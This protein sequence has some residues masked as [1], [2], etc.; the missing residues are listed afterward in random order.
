MFCCG[1]LKLP[2]PHSLK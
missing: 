1:R 2:W